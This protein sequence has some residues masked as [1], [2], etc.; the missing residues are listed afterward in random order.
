MAAGRARGRGELH[1]SL[2]T[3]VDSRRPDA[4]PERR[5]RRFIRRSQVFTIQQQIQATERNVWNSFP[6]QGDPGEPG[7]RRAVHKA[8][9]ITQH[10]TVTRTR[11]SF[12][13]RSVHGMGMGKEEGFYFSLLVLVLVFHFWKA[14][15]GLLRTACMHTSTSQSLLGPCLEDGEQTKKNSAPCVSSFQKFARKKSK[16]VGFLSAFQSC[17]VVENLPAIQGERRKC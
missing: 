6:R 3:S 8:P 10:N 16:K 7:G 12:F 15:A 1:R 5:L 14:R 2:Q 9:R 17:F 11:C 13:S 4:E